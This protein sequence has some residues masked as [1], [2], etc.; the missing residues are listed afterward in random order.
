LQSLK[1]IP[2]SRPPRLTILI[3]SSS[4]MFLRFNEIDGWLYSWGYRPN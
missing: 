4:S 1:V 2:F 3:C